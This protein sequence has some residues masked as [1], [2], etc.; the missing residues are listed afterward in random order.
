MQL[1]L[2]TIYKELFANFGIEDLIK[3]R[4][5]SSGD[6]KNY[7]SNVWMQSFG[8]KEDLSF[9]HAPTFDSLLY[10]LVVG[11]DTNK[12]HYSNNVEGLYSLYAG[13]IGSSQEHEDITIEQNAITLGARALFTDNNLFSGITSSLTVSDVESNDIFGKD[14]YNIYSFGISS[15]TGYNFNSIN[16]KYRIQ[17]SIMLSYIYGYTPDFENISGIQITDAAT[18]LLQIKP[19]IKLIYYANKALQ[20]Y[21]ELNYNWNINF[22]SQTMADDIILPQVSVEP[23]TE[24]TI[25]MQKN[26]TNTSSGYLEVSASSG[27]RKGFGGKIGFQ[28]DL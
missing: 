25:G 12:I 28:W 4:G 19:G 21:T 18:H 16:K 6:Q 1:S 9:E 10:G 20:T 2:A 23:Y 8:K 7:F 15:K 3:I 14:S 24:F 22:G 11:A 26:I 27:G 13:Y 17:P 5:L